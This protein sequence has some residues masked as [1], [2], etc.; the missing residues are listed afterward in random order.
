MALHLMMRFGKGKLH[1]NAA[2]I[3]LVDKSQR[4][5]LVHVIQK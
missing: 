5:Q 2:A 1:Q 3:Q 4:R